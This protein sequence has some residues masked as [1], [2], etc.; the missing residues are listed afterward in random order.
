MSLPEGH[1]TTSTDFDVVEMFYG[2]TYENFTTL[3]DY[4]AMWNNM[5]EGRRYDTF[6]KM[7]LDFYHTL[8]RPKRFDAFASNP[9][10]MA[11]CE[12]RDNKIRNASHHR[13]F[14]LDKASQIVRYR[15]EKGGSGPEQTISYV[16]YLE[17]CVRLFLQ[18]ITLLRLEL[19]I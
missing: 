2:N 9:T 4:I 16:A 15:A 13:S 10:F 7:N 1:Q 6:E 5:L 12:E 8:A 14:V 3:V 11:I 18:T 19:M 17:R